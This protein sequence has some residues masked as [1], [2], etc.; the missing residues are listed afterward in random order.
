MGAKRI[1]PGENETTKERV[2]D[3][4]RGNEHKTNM[5]EDPRYSLKCSGAA[6]W[7]PGQARRFPN[8]GREKF[9]HRYATRQF[10]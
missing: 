6:L 3:Q 5:T 9:C 7:L 8:I 1:A 4:T 2:R 10:V